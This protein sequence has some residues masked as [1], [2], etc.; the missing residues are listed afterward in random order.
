VQGEVIVTN[1]QAV[2]IVK[3]PIF[4][5]TFAIAFLHSRINT[6]RGVKGL[7]FLPS[8]RIRGRLRTKRKP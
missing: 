6:K 3:S 2:K 8:C 4:F 7:G 1:A 5:F